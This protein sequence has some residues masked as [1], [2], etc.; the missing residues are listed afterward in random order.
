MLLQVPRPVQP[1]HNVPKSTTNNSDHAFSSNCQIERYVS[2]I[3]SCRNQKIFSHSFY[4]ARLKTTTY[5]Y[6]AGTFT[7]FLVPL[8]TNRVL[9][10]NNSCLPQVNARQQNI[11]QPLFDMTGDIPENYLPRTRKA[12]HYNL[13]APPQLGTG[14][15]WDDNV[16][17][18]VDI[19]S[20]QY[21]IS[22][23]QAHPIFAATSWQPCR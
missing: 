18:P 1:L 4:S 10:V 17:A 2:V 22:C 7:N 3:L 23:I 9:F 15:E 21:R 14:Y 20:P 16:F 5:H 11:H 12:V 13:F 19:C 6:Q 8:Y